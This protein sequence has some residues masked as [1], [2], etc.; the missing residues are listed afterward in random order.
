MPAQILCKTTGT[1][2]ACVPT[3]YVWWMCLMMFHFLFLSEDHPTNMLLTPFIISL[4]T[5]VIFQIKKEKKKNYLTWNHSNMRA[6][7]LASIGERS[8]SLARYWGQYNTTF[9]T[10]EGL[11]MLA[12]C[13][14]L[15]RK[16]TRHICL[17]TL[18]LF[19]FGC[20]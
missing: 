12:S 20:L 2:F 16:S 14:F 13:M 4:Q 18:P 19:L 11:P 17:D 6:H 5:K 8:M 1:F 10:L 15:P 3:P 9:C 7:V